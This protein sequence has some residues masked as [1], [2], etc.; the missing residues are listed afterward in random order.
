[1]KHDYG[2]CSVCGGKLEPSWFVEEEYTVIDGRLHKTGRTRHAVDYLY[3][4]DCFHK[5]TVDDSFDGPWIG[6][7]YY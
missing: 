5:E 1:M 4:T 2:Q 3:C 6:R 7:S